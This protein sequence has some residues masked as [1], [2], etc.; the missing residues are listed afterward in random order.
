MSDVWSS[1]TSVGSVL[2]AV[3]CI[4][5]RLCGIKWFMAG[6]VVPVSSHLEVSLWGKRQS[7]QWEAVKYQED[8]MNHQ[9]SNQ[10]NNGKTAWPVAELWPASKTISEMQSSDSSKSLTNGGGKKWMCSACMPVCSY[11][12]NLHGLSS[13]APWRRKYLELKSYLCY[14]GLID[15]SILSILSE[16]NICLYTSKM[17]EKNT[18]DAIEEEAAD[19]W[20]E[21]I[22]AG[23]YEE[24]HYY[25]KKQVKKK[26][27]WRKA[28][29]GWWKAT[30]Q[31]K[32]KTIKIKKNERRRKKTKAAKGRRRKS[33]KGTCNEGIYSEENID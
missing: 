31:N 12:E 9:S 28:V 14:Y 15:Y 27:I 16:E 30:K 6:S 29:T 3:L 24:T 21:R 8:E 18:N 33:G 19:S 25:M 11:R 13:V 7:L 1:E 26:D 23:K 10:W 32:A 4:K 2:C 22:E 17:K 5:W 20:E